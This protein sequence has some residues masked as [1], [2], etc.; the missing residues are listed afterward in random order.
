MRNASLALILLAVFAV[1]ARA[2]QPTA[3]D[4]AIQ[5]LIDNA[6]LPSPGLNL[7]PN[8]PR[9]GA[10]AEL[11]TAAS[12]QAVAGLLKYLKMPHAERKYKKEALCTLAQIGTKEAID[13]ISEFQSWAVARRT[14]PPPFGFGRHDYPIDHFSPM[15]IQAA[16]E[17]RSADGTT[18][19]LF[20]R[21]YQA[22]RDDWFLTTSKDRKSWTNPVLLGQLKDPQAVLHD[23]AAVKRKLDE[24]LLDEDKDRLSDLLEA[25]LGT[26]PAKADSDADGTPDGADANPPTPAPKNKEA[27]DEQAEMRQAAFLVQYATS[28]STDVVYVTGKD[29]RAQEFLGYAGWLLPLEKPRMGFVNLTGIE[30]KKTSDTTAEGWINDYEANMAAAGF[31]FKL[32]K[33]QGKWVVVSMRLGVIS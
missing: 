28:N 24:F 26:D 25:R 17:A 29:I 20:Q 23:L 13:A 8:D 1:A 31:E 32:E 2:A 27:L 14:N 19:A 22:W 33:K 15:D 10:I 7:A 4:R 18:W 5:T 30:I 12:P 11:R 3:V 9:L 21:P 16:H 6:E